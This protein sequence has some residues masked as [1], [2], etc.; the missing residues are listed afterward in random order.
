M[1][2]RL[3]IVTVAIHLLV[4]GAVGNVRSFEFIRS[5]GNGMGQTVLISHTLPS[6]L[7]SV[8]TGGLMSKEW[9]FETGFDR[10]YD[11]SELDQFYAAGAYRYKRLTFAGGLSKFGRSDLYSEL[12]GKANIAYH[13]DS[14]TIGV[15]MS[16]LLLQFGG[17][18]GNL[19]GTTIGAGVSYR[20]NRLYTAIVAD[21]L[22][23][24]RLADDGP[25]VNPQYSVYAEFAGKQ[26]FVVTGR[27][28]LE[29]G[30]DTQFGFGQKIFISD[31]SAVFWGI[32]TSPLEYGSGLELGIR[33][34]T[35]SY[36]FSNHPVLGFSHTIAVSVG[37]GFKHRGSDREF[38]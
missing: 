28:T 14:L 24:P 1:K 3:F 17:N 25:K 12:T 19:S 26:S 35:I 18:Y 8:P 23:S 10:Q 21:N 13:Y 20:M 7:V 38:K 36:A 16:G 22:T 15:S 4:L 27:A 6:T 2:A 31:N 33:G 5:E 29:S 32:S 11:M 37:G 30:E 34:T 9:R